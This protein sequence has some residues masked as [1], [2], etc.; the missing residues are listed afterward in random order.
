MPADALVLL[1]PKNP[2]LLEPYLDIDDDEGDDEGEDESDLPYA[3]RLADGAFLVHTFQPFAVFQGDPDEGRV[4]LEAFAEVLDGAHDD[5][6]GV[7]FFPDEPA[8]E[9]D[10]YDEIVAE[11]EAARRGLWIPKALLTAAER[12]ARNA[13]LSRDLE[14]AKRMVAA[15]TGTEMTDED[16]QRAVAMAKGLSSGAPELATPFGAAKLLEDVQKQ[17][18]GAMGLVSRPSEDTVVV[19]VK[20]KTELEVDEDEVVD[21]YLLEDGSVALETFVPL[22]SR[23]DLAAEL[24][25]PRAAWIEEHEDPRGVPTFSSVH[26]ESLEDVGQY[27]A[28]LEVLGDEVTFLRV[29]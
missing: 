24:R 20:R 3:E 7:F 28:V 19:L 4:W 26:L 2:T 1:R 14:E 6:R 17:L 21:A 11:V 13:T 23:D 9:A 8:I 5:P 29:R 22:A 12:A 16:A 25:G 10:T 15:L 27:E 18:M